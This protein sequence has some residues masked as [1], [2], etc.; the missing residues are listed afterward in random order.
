MAR[1]RSPGDAPRRPSQ[2]P[3]YV[4][5]HADLDVRSAAYVA[6]LVAIVLAGGALL[7]GSNGDFDLSS[8]VVSKVLAVAGLLAVPFVG[9]RRPSGPG[10]GAP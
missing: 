5:W 6:A 4:P 7:L 10:R 8:Q 1:S 3:S 9:R 2:L